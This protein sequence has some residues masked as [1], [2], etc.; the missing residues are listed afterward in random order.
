M[1]WMLG[2]LLLALGGLAVGVDEVL[3]I[4]RPPAPE[5]QPAVAAATESEPTTIAAAYERWY[6]MA[7]LVTL[8][9]PSGPKPGLGLDNVYDARGFPIPR[10]PD[11]YS[12]RMMMDPSN[13]Q[14]ITEYLDWRKAAIR[15]MTLV[16]NQ[17]PEEAMRRGIVTPEVTSFGQARPTDQMAVGNYSKVVPETLGAPLLTSGQAR[18][19]GITDPKDI[20]RLP[21]EASPAGIEVYWYWS[22]HCAYCTSMARTWFAFAKEVNAAGYKAISIS[23]APL[24]TQAS[25]DN[26]GSELAA[27]IEMWKITWGEDVDRARNW[28]DWTETAKAFGVT[29]TPTIIFINRNTPKYP[30]IERLVGVQDSDSLRMT[31]ARVAGWPADTWPPPPV[32]TGGASTA[33]GSMQV[34][35][36]PPG[37][38][39]IVPPLP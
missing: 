22:H 21:G 10:L 14:Y 32:H 3:V 29:G 1:R 17:L 11:P 28:L 13:Q 34:V 19:L 38:T 6:R 15:R 37:T 24:T 5:P 27:L 39:P 26:A 33:E 12:L 18:D 36:A 7:Y 30:R 35:V 16:A 2:L 8:D 25:I 31:L 23:T 20:P 9:S 4:V